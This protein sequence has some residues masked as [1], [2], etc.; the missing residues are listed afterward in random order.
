MS[1][2]DFFKKERAVWHKRFV[3]SLIAGI[4]VAII[5]LFFEM[6][7]S[8]IVM[9]ASLGASA[10]I[11]TQKY[12]HKLTILRT[13]IESYLI[14][15]VVSLVVLFLLHQ[16]SFSFSIAVLLA[17]TLVTLAIY[18]GDA[19]HPPAISA[20]LSFILLDGNVWDTLL[21]FF[22]VIVLL[23][24]V[25]LLTYIF[26][27]EHLELNKFHHEFKKF[28]KEEVKRFKKKIS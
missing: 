24:I 5:T 8:N 25:K 19:F 4:A 13:V 2:I 28:E 23:I 17:V 1:W 3:P 21:I 7:A 20:A 27:Y 6:T 14:A 15:L 11:I 18:L 10:A 26:Y 16:F 9:F 22:S 12:V